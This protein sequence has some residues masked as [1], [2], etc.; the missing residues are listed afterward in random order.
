M[1]YGKDVECM[2][3]NILFARIEREQ[4]SLA[5]EQQAA[6][7]GRSVAMVAGVFDQCVAIALRGFQRG[8]GDGCV[9]FERND[10]DARIGER[11][12]KKPL[13]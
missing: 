1:T 12:D 2:P 8:E 13:Q 3:V 7:L 5:R 11:P 9:G 6:A 4:L 10:I